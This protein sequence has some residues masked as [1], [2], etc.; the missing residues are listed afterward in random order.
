MQEPLIFVIKYLNDD[1]QSSMF[2]SKFFCLIVKLY[3]SYW[4]YM[5][6]Y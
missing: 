1:R 4:Y 6:F 3:K 5:Y 2:L